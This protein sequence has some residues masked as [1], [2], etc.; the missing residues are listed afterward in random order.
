MFGF[1][2][3]RMAAIAAAIIGILLLGKYI[4]NTG[5]V[6]GRAEV[7]AKWDAERTRQQAKV[8]E[9]EK[10]NAEETARRLKQQQENQDAQ[11]KELAAARSDAA[12]NRAA[13]DGLRAQ[14]ADAARRWRD[15]IGNSPA[16]QNCPAAGDAIGVLADV[17]GRA[18][19][20]AGVLAEYAD[21]ARAAGLKCERD[22]DALKP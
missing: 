18:D 12:R 19:R 3:L 20:R 17:F 22:Y 1:S 15:A 8:I 7:Q 21:A 4:Q 11:D 9:E 6:A 5:K 13:A 16:G 14:T 10:A 2:Y